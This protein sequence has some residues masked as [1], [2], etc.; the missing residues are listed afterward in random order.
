MG[1][2]SGSFI[3]G[4]L[5]WAVSGRSEESDM[6]DGDKAAISRRDFVQWGAGCAVVNAVGPGA[7]QAGGHARA[8]MLS[9]MDY[10]LVDDLVNFMEAHG[11]DDD[12]DHV[13]LA[14]AALGVVHEAFADWH[15]TFW[16]HLQVAKDLHGIEEV[17]VID[18]RDCG[19][20]RLALTETAVDTLEKETTAHREYMEEF[21]RQLGERHPDLRVYGVLMALDGTGENIMAA[22]SSAG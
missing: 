1:R 19:A 22:A 12:Y 5:Q 6:C 21:A 13:V 8:L 10:R 16:Q 9:C 7:A 4:W 18:H 14:G 15:E 20:Y 17:I 2:I 3:P 11:F